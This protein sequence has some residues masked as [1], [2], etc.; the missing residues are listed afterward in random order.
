MTKHIVHK[1]SIV[2]S[3][4]LV[5]AFTACNSFLFDNEGDCTT[6]YQL[7]F[8]Y[9]WN[10]KF[11]DAFAH[12][13]KSVSVYAFDE[14]GK[15]A[16]QKAEKGAALAQDRYAMTLD[17][18]AGKYD[19]IAWCGLDNDAGANESFSVPQL[20]IG[21]ST[22][23]NLLCKLNRKH[24]AAGN[25][26]VDT[27]LYAL[28][29]GQLSVELPEAEDGST[30][31]YTM[32]LVKDTHRLRVIL[33][34]LSGETVNVS[35]FSFSLEDEN[36]LMNYDNS[37][38]ADEP[39]TYQAW[40]KEQGE[41]GVEVRE[42]QTAVKVAIADIST[43]RLIAGRKMYLTVRNASD[44]VIIK[45]PFIDYALLV[46]SKVSFAISNQE[47]LDRQDEYTMMFF[48]D[49]KDE[50]DATTLYINSWKV[51]LSQTDLG[52]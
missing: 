5:L 39:I 14:S 12:E 18:P 26:Y 45:V 44:K 31:T 21:T 46:K 6:T 24:D 2:L 51:V 48:L 9:D 52:E 1:L 22:K 50:W 8:R 49:E 33:Q 23:E 19:L 11:A 20:T 35:D 13:V 3:L 34:H 4:L 15:L 36:G 30:R 17:L 10:I 47:Y 41:A 29:H 16:W 27:D 28:Y 43:A 32:P 42:A 38:L 7:R 37:L 40:N 25:A